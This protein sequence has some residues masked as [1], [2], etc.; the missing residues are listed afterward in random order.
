MRYPPS[1]RKVCK[2]FERETLSL[3]FGLAA[4]ERRGDRAASPGEGCQV[5]RSV[6]RRFYLWRGAIC[7]SRDWRQMQSLGC[8]SW[9]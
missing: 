3:D 4:T 1:Y 9:Q 8:W 2:V 7:A 6:D 5:R